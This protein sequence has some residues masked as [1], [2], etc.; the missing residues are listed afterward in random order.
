MVSLVSGLLLLFSQP[1][2]LDAT[3]AMGVDDLVTLVE[4]V[5]VTRILDKTSLMVRPFEGNP[6][7]F[8]RELILEGVPT[9]SLV[10]EGYVGL[11]G[12]VFRVAASRGVGDESILVLK[13]DKTG[14]DQWRDNLAKDKK[15]RDD[16]NERY[17]KKIRGQEPFTFAFS[18]AKDGSPKVNRFGAKDSAFIVGAIEDNPKESLNFYI[19]GINPKGFAIGKVP[20]SLEGVPL[21]ITEKRVIRGVEVYYADARQAQ[22]HLK[23]EAETGKSASQ[24]SREAE[25]AKKE[26]L[27]ETRAL[28]PKLIEQMEKSVANY[29]KAVEGEEK[30]LAELSSKAVENHLASLKKAVERVRED[31]P[32]PEAEPLVKKAETAMEAGRKAITKK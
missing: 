28:I 19:K 11:T 27:G 17:M 8:Q 12:K 13:L 15:T 21:I 31:L 32:P 30:S 1:K 10:P 18:D 14:T 16:A 20:T 4:P 23:R 6:D 24:K 2:V 7:H 3:P 26:R 5:R 9:E 25:L 22:I 29:Q